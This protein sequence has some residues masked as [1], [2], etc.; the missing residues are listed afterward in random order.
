M[1]FEEAI[2]ALKQGKRVRRMTWANIDSDIEYITI[3]ENENCLPKSYSFTTWHKD[4]SGQGRYTFDLL[5]ADIFADDWE[6]YDPK[7]DKEKAS[8]LEGWRNGYEQARQESKDMYK[9]IN[10]KIGDL[11]SKV[12]ISIGKLVMEYKE[13]K[14][15]LPKEPSVERVV[16]DD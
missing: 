3:R 1:K 6:I 16:V 11:E 8:Y 10:E 2:V 7:T 15:K 5:V 4:G 9:Y 12:T 14:E 13:I